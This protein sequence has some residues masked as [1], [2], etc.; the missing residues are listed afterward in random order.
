MQIAIIGAGNVGLALASNFIKAGHG[1][2]LAARDADKTRQI[3][4]SVG[5]W[6]PPRAKEAVAGADVVII[7]IPY[8][9]VESVARSIASVT[10]G[11]VVID[12]T[13]PLKA[14]YSGLATEGGPSGAERLAK[15]LPGA[16][17]A[18]AFNTVLA[19]LQANPDLHGVTLDVLFATDDD[20]ARQVLRDL[21]TSSGFRA[22]DAGS[23]VGARELEALA[24]LNIKLNASFNGSWTSSA[25]FLGLP[26]GATTEMA[27]TTD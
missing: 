1:V 25:V 3:A 11:K 8:G 17:V 6:G 10:A 24:W 9:E 21:I 12:A 13:N 14:D 4:S 18:K 19:S 22:V 26:A 27:R 7:A 20:H 15:V 16:A 2:T 23:L 5:A